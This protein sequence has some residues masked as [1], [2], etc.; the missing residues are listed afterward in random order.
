MPFCN[1][2]DAFLVRRSGALA[3]PLGS[4]RRSHANRL[5]ALVLDGRR[6]LLPAWECAAAPGPPEFRRQHNI[7]VWTVNSTDQE[8]L[9]SSMQTMLAADDPRQL[10]TGHSGFA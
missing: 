7:F 5:F 9:S 6:P 8:A 1:A 4:T 10:V 3:V 2:C